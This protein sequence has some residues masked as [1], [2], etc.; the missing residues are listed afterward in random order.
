MEKLAFQERWAWIKTLEFRSEFVAQTSVYNE[1][2]PNTPNPWKIQI[3]MQISISFR[4]Q[5]QRFGS[6]HTD[7]GC[8]SFAL[9]ACFSRWHVASCTSQAVRQGLSPHCGESLKPIPIP[10]QLPEAFPHCWS[11]SV[12]WGKAPAAFCVRERLHQWE[13]LLGCIESNVGYMSKGSGI[14]FTVPHH[15][16]IAIYTHARGYI[17]Y[18]LYTPP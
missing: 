4:I 12:W 8:L 1:L 7:I 3:K 2:N 9:I 17:V 13:A 10:S 16:H 5:I 14:V 18:V 6:A 11:L 15:L